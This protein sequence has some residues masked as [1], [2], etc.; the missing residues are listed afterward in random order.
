M[1][2]FGKIFWFCVAALFLI[3]AWL[4][5]HIGGLLLRLA[6]LIPFDA[7]KAALA[8]WLDKLPPALAFVAFAVPIMLLEP[9]KVVAIW[10]IGHEQILAG[11]LLFA[12]AE[13]LTVGVVA[14]LFDA[15]RGKLLSMRW[16]H[17]VYDRI[18]R[19]RRWAD[20]LILPY[21][22]KLAAALASL[23]LWAQERLA[24][25]AQSPFIGRL[26]AL[27]GQARRMRKRA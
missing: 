14:F 18:L 9:L 7:F 10:L 3:E 5:D 15:M 23:T 26:I 25:H 16:F 2:L 6:A 22:L 17:R 12:F 27:R 4:W 21:R 8:G 1:Q 13:A 24:A 19:V 11:V 20:I